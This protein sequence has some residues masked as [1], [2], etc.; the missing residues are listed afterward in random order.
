MMAQIN[1]P[2]L[3]CVTT[4]FNGDVELTWE[5]PT[6]TC[7]TQ[8]NGYRIYISSDPT[9]P[10][11]LLTIV[12]N[13]TQTTY[14]HTGANGTSLTWYYYMTTDLL[15]PNE[16]PEQSLTLDNQQPA[17]TE[18]D[19]VTVNDNGNVEL[20]WFENPS[21]ETFAYIILWSTPS[22]FVA[23]DTIFG[24]SSVFYEHTGSNP[25]QQ[26][27]TY[28]IVAM[29][30]CG[31]TG[32]VNNDPHQTILL[33]A[34]IDRCSRQITL[35][36]TPYS[37]WT[38]GVSAHQIW[39]ARNGGAYQFIDFIGDSTQHIYY[40]AND[41]E[42]LC[43]YVSAVQSGSSSRSS[44][45]RICINVDVVQPQT[46]IY[47]RNLTVNENNEVQVD[48]RWDTNAD[49]LNYNILRADTIFNYNPVFTT[50]PTGALSSTN[51]HI[52]TSVDANIQP[53]GYQ[54]E[55]MDSCGGIINSNAGTTIHLSGF[56]SLDF[57]NVLNW[58]PYS[59]TYGSVED[60][61]IYKIIDGAETPLETVDFLTYTF[62]D[63]IDGRDTDEAN[64]C[65]FIVARVE[66]EYP[67]GSTE[68]VYSRSNTFCLDQPVKIQVPNAF[69]PSGVNTEFKPV[70]VFGETADFEMRI[71]NRWGT[72]VFETTDPNQ[73]WTGRNQ[74]GSIAL[75]GVYVYQIKVTQ[76]NGNVVERAGT[77]MLVR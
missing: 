12:T 62:D 3:T 56:A 17:T 67:D 77:V 24:R 20:H 73:G 18:I 61:T 9:Q 23:I 40:D 76:P 21:P 15:C 36:W 11:S 65:Y 19:F 31:N 30:K 64:R 5:I 37:A 46:F 59:I 4:L 34:Q 6:N 70:L 7:G 44:T 60:Y 28:T 69:V 26:Q 71:F 52:D 41:G 51:T 2:N 22:G 57:K 48:W 47:L 29:D 54:L 58:T 68:T 10:F 14:T 50:N 63:L 38:S 39:M 35:N 16:V 43:F 53:Y 72:K 75:Q 25:S 42:Q 55:S 49:L 27:E 1:P 33:G 66:M 45:N 32:L 13:P 8:F 74:S